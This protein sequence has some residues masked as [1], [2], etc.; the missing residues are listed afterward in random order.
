MRV[1]RWTIAVLAC[2]LLF[3]SCR[4][5]DRYAT[6]VDRELNSGKRVDSIFFDIRFGMTSK[7]F[8]MYCWN[9]NKKG[10]FTDGLN[11]Q[12][13]LYKPKEKDFRYRASMNFYPDFSKGRISGMRVLYQ[14]DEWAPWNKHLFADSLL[15]DVLQLY[16]RMYPGGNDFLTIHNKQRG[17]IY[18]KV[19]GNR[20]ITVGKFNDMIVKADF[21]DLLAEKEGKN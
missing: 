18:V 3:Q 16:Q 8:Y 5:G 19:D 1:F 13:V 4:Q 21:T 6:L 12:Y 2:Q 11:N 10:I 17:D 9:M 20:R 14:Y 15:K 7:D